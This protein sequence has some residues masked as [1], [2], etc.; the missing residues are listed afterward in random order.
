MPGRPRSSPLGLSFGEIN[1]LRHRK[2]LSRTH[3]PLSNVPKA[4]ALGEGADEE[5]R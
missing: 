4:F 1:D 3:A 2:R 5:D